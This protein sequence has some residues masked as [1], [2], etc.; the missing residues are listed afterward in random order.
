MFS[1]AP[2]AE[3]RGEL[4]DRDAEHQ[5]GP[6][7]AANTRISFTSSLGCL[8]ADGQRMTSVTK[9]VEVSP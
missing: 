2:E 9:A 3:I 8:P 5:R 1:I 7:L 6:H 4:S